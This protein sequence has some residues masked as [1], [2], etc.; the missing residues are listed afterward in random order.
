MAREKRIIKSERPMRAIKS[1]PENWRVRGKL[2]TPP[3]NPTD[4]GAARF[5]PA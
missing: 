5:R 4:S 3:Q 1:P 2:K